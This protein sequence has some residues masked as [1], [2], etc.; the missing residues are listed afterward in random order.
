LDLLTPYTHKSEL[1]TITKLSLIY[2]LYSS[3]L[4]HALGFPV[5]TSRILTTDLYHFCCHF[6][7]YMKRYFRNLIPFLPLFCICQFRRLDS[8]QFLCS[9]AHILAGWRLEIRLDSTRLRLLKWFLLYKYF[10]RTT[11]KTRSLCVGNA[12]CSS[13]A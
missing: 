1:Q 11:Q 10:T 9:Q 13:V 12:C 3:P 8:V 4:Q 6:K 2:T 7:L 5:F